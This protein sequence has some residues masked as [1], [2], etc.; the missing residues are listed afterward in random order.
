MTQRAVQTKNFKNLVDLM[1]FFKDEE[2]CHNFL[3]DLFW[4]KNRE[5]KKCPRCQSG[6]IV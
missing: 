6:F 5:N 4:G 3:K 2:F 1:D